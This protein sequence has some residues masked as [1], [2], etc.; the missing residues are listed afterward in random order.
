MRPVTARPSPCARGPRPPG[1]S[2][3]ETARSSALAPAG[4][5]E[6]PPRSGDGPSTRYAVRLGAAR[7]ARSV[8]VAVAVTATG[9]LGLVFLLLHDERVGGEHH[10]RDR[11]GVDQRGAGDLDRVDDA[12]LDQVAV[13]ARGGVEAVAGAELAHLG[14]GDVALHAGVLGDPAQRLGRGL[15]DDQRTGRLVALEVEVVDGGGGVDEGGA[16]TG[17]DALLDGRAG[18]RDGVLDA[19]LLLLELHLGVGTH[20]DDADATGELGEALL[21]L[22]AVPVGVGA[23][24]LGLDLV[25]PAGDVVGRAGAVDDRGGVLGDDD[26]AGLAQHVEVGLVELEPDLLGDDLAA[27]EGGHVLQHRLAAVAEAGGLDGHDVE[28]A[29]DLVD[30][31]GRQRLAVDVLGDD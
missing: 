15:L 17:D 29:A 9:G 1:P 31:Q 6:G 30:H 21:E 4:H 22:L 13:L 24:D 23:L 5:G 11:G 16:A 12:G 25:D 27:G 14:D 3:P 2:A 20:L 26:A 8:T 28:R 7:Q 18:R 19:V 10:R